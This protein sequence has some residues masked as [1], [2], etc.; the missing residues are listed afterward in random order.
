MTT[1]DLQM[2]TEILSQLGRLDT[3]IDIMQAQKALLIHRLGQVVS[4]RNRLQRHLISLD[5]ERNGRGGK[6]AC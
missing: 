1:R 5:R 3:Q 2:R 4:E 6:E